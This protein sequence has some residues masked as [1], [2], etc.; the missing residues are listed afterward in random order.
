MKMLDETMISAIIINK[1][2]PEASFRDEQK[3]SLAARY[4]H[5]NSIRFHSFREFGVE[6]GEENMRL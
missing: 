4:K 6:V 3:Q 2:I 5:F 1:A